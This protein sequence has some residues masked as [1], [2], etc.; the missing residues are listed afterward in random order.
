MKRFFPVVLIISIFG[1]AFAINPSVRIGK[2]KDCTYIMVAVDGKEPARIDGKDKV[3][4]VW[5]M[6]KVDTVAARDVRG[7]PMA[8]KLSFYK[9]TGTKPVDVLWIKSTGVWGFDGYTEGYGRNTEILKWVE[10][11]LK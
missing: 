5:G 3:R 11:E 7:G 8:Y 9:D 10:K 2:L 1:L 6:F 4:K